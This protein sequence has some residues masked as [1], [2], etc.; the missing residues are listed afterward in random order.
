MFQ[1]I[2]DLKHF[3]LVNTKWVKSQNCMAGWLEGAN[4]VHDAFFSVSCIKNKIL[5]SGLDEVLKENN[6]ICILKAFT[7][8]YLKLL[9]SL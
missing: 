3:A 7:E 6:F 5:T 8:I 9:M 2:F 1:F 4:F